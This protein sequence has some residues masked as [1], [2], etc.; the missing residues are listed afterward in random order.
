MSVDIEEGEHMFSNREL[1]R[2]FNLTIGAPDQ[3]CLRRAASIFQE[4]AHKVLPTLE[5]A[6][7]FQYNPAL[8]PLDFLDALAEFLSRGYDAPV[9]RDN[10]VM[11]AGA[12]SGMSLFA[13][14]FLS[15]GNSVVFT[16]SPTYFI[17]RSVLEGSLGLKVVPVG[18][19]PDGS[20]VNLIELEQAFERES[21]KWAVHHEDGGVRDGKH[22]AMFYTI[23]AFH[24]PTGMHTWAVSL[25]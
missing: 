14:E 13:G 2:A 5:A 3:D 25:N 10:L 20:G 17:A 18:I 22:W 15:T 1:D 23:P 24:N 11:T 6:T 9:R 19:D 21:S 4:Y 7:A 12:T 8:G 16:E